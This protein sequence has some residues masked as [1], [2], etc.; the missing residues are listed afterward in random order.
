MSTGSERVVSCA[1]WAEG[2][3]GKELPL[4]WC[5]LVVARV[6][7][8]LVGWNEGRRYCIALLL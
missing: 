5:L 1:E 3:K 8:C 6:L 2:E 7:A 4:L